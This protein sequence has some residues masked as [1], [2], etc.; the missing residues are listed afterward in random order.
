MVDG[1]NDANV[2]TD[3]SPEG[4]NPKK[5]AREDG[6]FPDL[7]SP[8]SPPPS[9]GSICPK[10]SYPTRGG[11]KKCPNCGHSLTGDSPEIGSAPIHASRPARSEM[12]AKIGGTVIA[13]ATMVDPAVGA[14]AKRLVGFLVT[15]STTPNGE[16]FQIYEGRNYVGRDSAVDIRIKGD[17]QVSEKHFSILY[18]AVDKKFKFRDEMSSNGTFVN[19]ML[20]DEGELNNFDIIRIGTTRLIFMAI[21]Q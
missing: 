1:R 15:Y 20:I 12:R 9:N 10:C 2:G 16:S 8:S 7:S 18:R 5:T 14:P 13:G 3:A 21:P 19:E 11:E 17:T 4:F 6:I